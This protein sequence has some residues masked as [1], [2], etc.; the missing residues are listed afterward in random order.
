M[1][2]VL[3]SRINHQFDNSGNKFGA[4]DEDGANERIRQRQK[5]AEDAIR[6]KERAIYLKERRA[7]RAMMKKIGDEENAR[8]LEEEKL[9]LSFGDTFWG[10]D[11]ARAQ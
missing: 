4:I 3:D 10:I 7:K 8:M 6:A 11:K 2:S 1:K 5:E 9:Q